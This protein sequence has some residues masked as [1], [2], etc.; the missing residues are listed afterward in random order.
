MDIYT[1]DVETRPINGGGTYAALEPWR[2]RQKKAEIS[3]MAVCYPDNSIVQIKNEGNSDRWKFQVRSTLEP[4]KGKRVF[5]HNA[6]FDVAWLICTLQPEKFRSIPPDIFN[7][8]W[9]DTM[10]LVKWLINGQKPEDA[11]FSYSLANLVETFLPDHPSTKMFLEI[12]KQ[13]IAA[14][15]NPKY[16]EARGDLDVL[17]TKALAEKFMA[18]VPESMRIGLMTEWADIV[19]TANA[20]SNG[21][22]IDVNGIEKVD[23]MLT[24][25]MKGITDSLHVEGSVLSS[26]QQL[27][28]LLFNDWGLT[29]WSFT[30]TGKACTAGDDIMWIQYNLK[31]NDPDRAINLG[32]VIKYKENKTLQSK[33]VNTLKAALEYTEDGYIYGIPKLFGT[34]TGRMTYSNTTVKNGPKVSIALHQLPR[35]KSENKNAK[36]VRAIRSL[37]KA[38]DGFGVIE[39]DAAGQESRLMAIRSGDPTML[40][41]FR[42]GLDFHSMTA[43]AII[44]M[45]YY[46]FMKKYKEHET[47]YFKEQ[48][49]LGKLDNLSCNYRIGGPALANKAFTEYD[50]FMT[51]ETGRFLV[52]TF[53]RQYS[54]VPAYWSDVIQE[55]KAMGYTEAYGGRRYKLSKWTN[56]YRWMTESS[57]INFPIQGAGGSMKEIAIKEIGEKIPE[58]L[59]G[60]DLHDATFNF[61]SLDSIDAVSKEM[62]SVL[63]GI[64]YKKYWGFD[65]PIPLTYEAGTGRNFGG[66]K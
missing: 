56:K 2:A 58:A 46:D 9:A 45:D 42:D 31:K 11:R 10:T 49:Q 16:W 63:N 21:I 27:G 25:T 64:D 66:V 59:F 44:G 22:P 17:M 5:A 54:G 33:Y 35:I 37:L 47:G 26:P 12:K 6:G 52:N 65:T 29:P 19:H 40:E 14:G 28:N 36:E 23:D 41:I 50:T 60:L 38:P 15:Q 13:D 1:L 51:E 43:A 32:K 30:P 57:A 48:R 55:S 8:K 53:A 18:K 7:I 34:Y 61:V 24:S 3:S 39:V 4:L 20:W 62:I